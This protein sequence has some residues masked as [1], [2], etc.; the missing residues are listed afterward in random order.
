MTLR[1]RI[2]RVAVVLFLLVNLLGAGYAAIEG[3]LVHACVH[4]GLVLLTAF[5]VWR[6][7]ARR[8]NSY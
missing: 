7:S 5:L 4:A 8:A 3:E 2:W 1:S 6:S